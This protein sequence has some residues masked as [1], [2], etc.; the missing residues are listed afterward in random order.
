MSVRSR[1]KNKRHSFWS[2]ID[3]RTR[4]SLVIQ[5]LHRRRRGCDS[6]PI[7]KIRDFQSGFDPDGVATKTKG[8]PFGVLSI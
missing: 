3:E 6:T 4:I 5:G 7:L 1:N 2:A 8:T